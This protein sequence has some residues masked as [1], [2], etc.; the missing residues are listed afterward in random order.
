MICNI[1]FDVK[2]INSNDNVQIRKFKG[3]FIYFVKKCCMCGE[4]ILYRKI[5]FIFLI[6]GQNGRMGKY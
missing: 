2:K 3:D 4:N 6:H 1:D 5:F